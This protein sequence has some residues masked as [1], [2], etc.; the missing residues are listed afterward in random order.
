MSL[1]KV[2]SNWAAERILMRLEE[3]DA[4][5][6]TPTESSEEGST[7]TQRTPTGPQAS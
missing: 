6:G 2:I 1:Q 4:L 7:E 5:N 3:D